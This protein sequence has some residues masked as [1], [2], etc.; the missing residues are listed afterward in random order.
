MPSC[1]TSNA[2][3]AALSAEWK[4]LSLMADLICH[5]RLQQTWACLPERQRLLPS[6]VRYSGAAQP[7][8]FSAARLQRAAAA[9][10]L[11]WRRF[12]SLGGADWCASAGKDWRRVPPG[13]LQ[14][15]ICVL[16]CRSMLRLPSVRRSNPFGFR[17]PQR[18]SSSIDSRTPTGSRCFQPD[19]RTKHVGSAVLPANESAPSRTAFVR[20]RLSRDDLRQAL[21]VIHGTA[22]Q[23]RPPH[24]V[25]RRSLPRRVCAPA[26]TR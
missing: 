13:P 1:S 10:P 12:R 6:A 16:S 11:P 2:E 8:Q 9:F 23:G 26:F 4:R 17:S 24:R 25:L 14:R 19:L 20:S 15:D 3:D 7:G 22:V 18:C 5:A 21:L